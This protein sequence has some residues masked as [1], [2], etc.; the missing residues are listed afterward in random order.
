MGAA[1]SANLAPRTKKIANKH[2]RSVSAE[3]L[4]RDL[5]MNRVLFERFDIDNDGVINESE[6]LLMCASLINRN[7]TREELARVMHRGGGSKQILP[8]GIVGAI[9]EALAIKEETEQ[10]P[11]SPEISSPEI[12]AA[13]ALSSLFQRDI[14]H[15]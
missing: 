3:R 9:S 2:K 14:Y 10:P 7:L 6:A 1:A 13:A 11:L 15:L 12:D 5:Q 8:A 4:P